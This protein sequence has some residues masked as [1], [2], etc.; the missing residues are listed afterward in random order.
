M[1]KSFDPTSHLVSY[2]TRNMV[3]YLISW[4]FSRRAGILVDVEFNTSIFSRA[5]CRA[6]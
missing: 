5:S 4:D 3:K 2:Q 1:A 6:E